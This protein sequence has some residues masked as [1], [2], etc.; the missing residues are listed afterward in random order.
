ML[1]RE[2]NFIVPKDFH[3]V[4]TK[5][6]GV[7]A[8]SLDAFVDDRNS[9]INQLLNAESDVQCI[10]MDSAYVQDEELVIDVPVTKTWYY[11]YDILS[12]K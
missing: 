1:Q 4:Q 5:S 2:F 3:F 8:G 9:F 10:K 11:V 6:K 7:F 12:N